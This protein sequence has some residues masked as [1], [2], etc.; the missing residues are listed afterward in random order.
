MSEK[1]TPLMD[2]Y[3]KVKKKYPDAILLFRV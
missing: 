3:N 2:Q 1:V